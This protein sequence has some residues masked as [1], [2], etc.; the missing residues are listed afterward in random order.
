[1]NYKDHVKNKLSTYNK[2][3]IILTKHAQI[4]AITR[5]IEKKEIIDNIINPKRLY[6]AKKQ[7]S[8]SKTEEKYDCYFS[9]SKTQCQR[10]I[11]VLKKKCIVCTII[12][13]NRRWQ[14][15]VEKYAKF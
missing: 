5:G 8:N 11:L 14:K 15:Q 1:M 3:D 9:Y 4:Q 7:P 2:K 6:F 12:K 10:Y 13:I